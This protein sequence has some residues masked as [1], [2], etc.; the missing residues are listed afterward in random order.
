MISNKTLVLFSACILVLACV[1]LFPKRAESIEEWVPAVI[2]PSEVQLSFRN[3][4]GVS[5]VD[6]LIEFPS[7]GYNV[8]DWG[9]P[10]FFVSNITAVAEIWVW[11]GSVLPVI[12]S[13]SHTYDLGS[14]SPGEYL[15]IFLGG[16]ALKNITFVIPNLL[17]PQRLVGGCSFPPRMI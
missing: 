3:E 13:V 8:S 12:I 16:G 14:L 5:F 17:T 15:F 6:V 11:T 1:S 4:N 7:S 10:V 9:T 2:D